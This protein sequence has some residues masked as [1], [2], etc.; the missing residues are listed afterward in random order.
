MTY[1]LTRFNTII[2]LADGA[3]IPQADGNRDYREYLEWLAEG[4]ESEPADAPPLPPADWRGFLAAL[5]GTTVF[6][7][8]RSQART[9]V[10]ANALATELRTVLGEAALGMAEPAVVQ[11]LVTELLPSLS[12][13]QIEEIATAAA[14]FHIPLT[15]E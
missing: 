8:L 7:A 14:A 12:A 4:N 2:R 15:L 13:P 6:S 9:D 11:A 3:N 1:K 5:R 10:A